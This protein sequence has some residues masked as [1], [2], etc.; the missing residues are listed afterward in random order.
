MR[1]V[2]SHLKDGGLPILVVAG[3]N[4]FLILCICVLLTNHLVPRFG[5]KVHPQTSHFVMG[6]YDRDR[7][8]VVSV[9]PG[10]MPRLYVGANLVQG[11]YE[12]FEKCL[13]EWGQNESNPSRISVVLVLDKAVSAGMVQRLSDMVLSHGFT[14]CYAGVP[15]LE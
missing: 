4:L 10:D 9:A 12:G 5:F 2:R 14:C 3:V 13:A 11:G 1:R 6:S 15:A 8:H 7:T